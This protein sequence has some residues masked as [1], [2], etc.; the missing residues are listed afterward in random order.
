MRHTSAYVGIRQHTSAYV[1]IRLVVVN[2]ILHTPQIVQSSAC[3]QV[4]VSLYLLNIYIYVSIY[5]YIPCASAVVKKRV[6][7][8]VFSKTKER[9]ICIYI[10]TY[11]Y[12]YII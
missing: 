9:I 3:N 8:M 10:Y 1:S 11:I 12:I 7:K 4:L 6:I 5:R 2:V